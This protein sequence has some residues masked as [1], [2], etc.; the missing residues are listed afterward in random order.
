MIVPLVVLPAGGG[1]NCRAAISTSTPGLPDGLDAIALGPTDESGISLQLR[2]RGAIS[3]SSKIQIR[4]KEK[5]YEAYILFVKHHQTHHCCHSGAFLS[6]PVFEPCHRIVGP[7]PAATE[8]RTVGQPA[9]AAALPV[10][11]R[12]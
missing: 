2:C 3:S 5:A 9:T 11:R 12:D 8:G 4:L 6:H 7:P 10:W 1:N